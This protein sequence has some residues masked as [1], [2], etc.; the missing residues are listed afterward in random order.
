MA[1]VTAALR[2]LEGGHHLVV[3]HGGV[4]RALLGRAGITDYPQPASVHRVRVTANGDEIVVGRA[5]SH[6]RR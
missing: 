4:I 5:E 3:T 2:A 1:R 6:G